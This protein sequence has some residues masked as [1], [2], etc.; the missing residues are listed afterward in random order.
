MVFRDANGS[1]TGKDNAGNNIFLNLS[2]ATPTCSF[3]GVTAIHKSAG[4][5][6]YS[7]S[8]GA[9]VPAIAVG[10]AG[11]YIVTVSDNSGCSKSDTTNVI[12][13]SNLT[14]NLGRDTSI[15]P[16]GHMTF[17]AGTGFTSYHWNTG[18]TVRSITVSAAGIYSVT[19]YNGN[20]SAVDSVALTISGHKV[21][22]GPDM[23][24]CTTAPVTITAPSGYASY[25]WFGIGTSSLTHSALH[26]GCYW[27]KATD[28]TGCTSYDTINVQ[29]SG[30]NGM[31]GH[32]TLK[33]C[34][35]D[36]TRFDA[37][38]NVNAA[39][40]SL[41]IIYDATKGQTQLQGSHKVYMH[42]APE[43]YPFTGWQGNYTVGN[44]GQDD[45]VGEMD[46]IGPN[47]WSI[48]IC[49]SCY[50]HFSPDT[51]LNSIFIAFRN[52]DGTKTG[53]D[54]LGNNINIL[55]VGAGT[56]SSSFSGIKAHHQA[57][58]NIT[59][60]WSTGANSA[61]A[62]FNTAGSYYVTAT[63]G[64]CSRID[65]VVVS[66]YASP[67]INLGNDTCISGAA[68]TLGV[69]GSYSTYL[70]STGAPTA[71]IT[72]NQ[73]GTYWLRVA[74]SNGCKASDTI[75]VSSSATINLGHDTCIKSG[76]QV[77]L[78]AGSGA[79]SYIWSN[80][81]TTDTITVSQPGTYWVKVTS[82][83]GCKASDTI[84]ISTN[85][86]VSLGH[87]TCVRGPILLTA[88]STGASSYLWNNNATTDTITVN[89]GTY[90]VKVTGPNGCKAYDT[91][92]IGSFPVVHLGVDTC[93]VA[94]GS[95][96]LHAGV[97]ASGYLWNTGA[98]SDTLRVTAAGTYSVAVSNGVC[99]ASDTVIVSSCGHTNTGCR[100][101]AYFRILSIT[102]GGLVT[103]KDSSTYHGAATYHWD[104]GDGSSDTT[105][106]TNVHLYVP[107][108]AMY[109]IRLIVCSD[110]CGCDTFT[111]T[112]NVNVGI[113]DIQ[114][115]STINIHPNPASD[116]CTIEVNTDRNNDVDMILTDIMGASV[117]S[118]KWVL[119]SGEN[120]L[121]L[122]VSGLASGMYQ[123]LLRSA[124]GIATRK[125][126]IIK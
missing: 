64:V 31:H 7:W 79:A 95:I 74:T 8:T 45:G 13:S 78:L 104:Y 41:V 61:S 5:L 10:T 126:N 35:G 92:V 102:H 50:Y 66:S 89:Q 72:A 97:G 108:N 44:W 54:S 112:I 33:V 85:P 57:S 75:V 125:L 3:A 124:S 105:R 24:R 62:S 59:Y 119:I 4:T 101:H 84:V 28:S 113:N 100:P 107:N 68:V 73:P 25:Q 34:T 37:S 122:D 42:S 123:V 80:A 94:G 90:W 63:E 82:A 106:G 99:S 6:S 56:P 18:D 77:M 43:F 40:D 39:G 14:V 19:V 21:N 91:I 16:S 26:D 11:Q 117:L 36:S 48:T 76:S 98:T 83:N 114:G 88:V 46:S 49:P 23:T 32:D 67:T 52:A 53:K 29:T 58:G 27:I 55:L 103:I 110:T 109:T 70:W 115:V 20:C 121:I 60:A 22:L 15:C 51:P 71:T 1:H 47:L 81:A 30:V 9:N 86:S 120:K 116:K 111:Q 118:Q 87:D 93:V 17:D 38:V 96:T 69:S 65:T 2:T 12:I